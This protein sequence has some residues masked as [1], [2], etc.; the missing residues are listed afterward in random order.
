MIRTPRDSAGG[1]AL[2]RHS[3]MLTS[4]RLGQMSS[5]IDMFSRRFDADEL[6]VVINYLDGVSNLYSLT[7]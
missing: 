7:D 4:P 3:V 5:A 1:D 2:E 6:G